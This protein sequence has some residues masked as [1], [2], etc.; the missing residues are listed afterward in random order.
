MH[1]QGTCSDMEI[2]A[3]N[4]N[5]KS[6]K[7]WKQRNVSKCHPLFHNF[8]K[9]PCRKLK[10]ISRAI[11]LPTKMRIVNMISINVAK[12]SFTILL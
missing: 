3:K 2:K 1:A 10:P 9:G 7:N 5:S 6:Q 11:K 4:K 8:V 12:I